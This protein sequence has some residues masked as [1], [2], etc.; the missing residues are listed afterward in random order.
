MVNDTQLQSTQCRLVQRKIIFPQRKRSIEATMSRPRKSPDASPPA[1]PRRYGISGPISEDQPS[2]DQ[3]IL[4]EQLIKTLATCDAFVDDLEL[5][6][7]ENA[8]EQLESLFKEW[9]TEI[10]KELNIPDHVTEKVGGK[11]F[12][13]GSRH[14]GVDSKDSSRET[15][16]SPLSLRS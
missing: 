11:I 7:R 8:V 15:T 4:T 14:L 10:C 9:L 6:R 1:P 16:S 13:F 5:R 12:T 3:L 2:E